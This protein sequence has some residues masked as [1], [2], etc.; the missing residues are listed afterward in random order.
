[1]HTVLIYDLDYLYNGIMPNYMA[2]RI[3]SYHKQK[4]DEVY[5]IK[6]DCDLKGHYD[7][8]YV[9]R[10]EES[11]LMCNIDCLLDARNRVCGF[12]NLDNWKV[13]NII[14]SCRP[15]YKLYPMNVE[16]YIIP[17]QLTNNNGKVLTVKQTEENHIMK[18]IQTHI[19]M[20]KNLWTMSKIDCSI[21][22]RGLQKVIRVVF[23][24][25]VPLDYVLS[26]TAITRQ[27]SKLNFSH[28][29]ANIWKNN[30]P[31]NKVNLEKVSG[32][33]NAMEDNHHFSK[34]GSIPFVCDARDDEAVPCVWKAI[35]LQ[36]I[37]RYKFNIKIRHL[38]NNEQ[39][40]TLILLH[41]FMQS[42][43]CDTSFLEYLVP[44][45]YK[46]KII[47]F[48]SN[49]NLLSDATFLNK[50]IALQTLDYYGIHDSTLLLQKGKNYLPKEEISWQTLRKIIWY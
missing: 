50:K 17:I 23:A 40:K 19:I 30:L 38:S 28:E 22:L 10:N 21:A 11:Q 9:I 5:L 1:M 35:V 44:Y 12:E 4:G 7:I 41:D 16:D 24:E 27:I 8:M 34:F 15:D 2:M 37:H 39:S 6:Q 36:K 45:N 49:I 14:M 25:P 3:S 31:M 46:N 26:N 18:L 13:P 33:F 42:N 20:D 43:E 47:E 48:Y 32:L 29:K